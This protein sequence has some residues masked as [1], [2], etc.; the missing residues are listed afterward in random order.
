V[1]VLRLVQEGLTNVLKHAG[2]GVP[3]QLA[4]TAADGVR[5]EITNDTSAAVA[6]GNGYGLVGLDERVALVGGT[7]E[8]GPMPDGWRLLARLPMECARDEAVL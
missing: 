1:T 8:A 6:S 4:I 2:P 5:V 3:A 7:F